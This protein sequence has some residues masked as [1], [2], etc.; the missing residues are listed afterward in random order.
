[1]FKMKTKIYLRLLY[2]FVWQIYKSDYH[3]S[4]NLATKLYQI[5]KI[6]YLN[7]CYT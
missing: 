5:V 4:S 1:M 3:Q 6:L 7:S 2:K